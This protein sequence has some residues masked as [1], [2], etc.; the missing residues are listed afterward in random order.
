MAKQSVKELGKVLPDHIRLL[1]GLIARKPA[2]FTREWAA[3]IDEAFHLYTRTGIVDLWLA[4]NRELIEFGWPF[5]AYLDLRAETERVPREWSLLRNRRR[6]LLDAVFR[7][8]GVARITLYAG[9]EQAAG[10]DGQ[11]V[12][13]TLMVC[14]FRRNRQRLFHLLE[15]SPVL[16]EKGQ[17]VS[18]VQ[19]AF[20]RRFWAACITTIVPLLD[21]IMRSYFGTEKLNV[22]IQVLRDAFMREANLRPKD[23]MP[24]YA[25]WEGKRDPETGNA[26]APT[27]EEDLR[28]P[29]VL[30]S[31]FFEFADR[32]YQWYR[33]T[34]THP[35]TPLNRHA[36][37][38]CASEFW[39]Q[40]NAVRMLTFLD[41]TLRLEKPLKVLVHGEEAAHALFPDK[42]DE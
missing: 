29:G 20:E 26:F 35:Q 30:L 3:S 17:I 37:M 40:A 21:Y 8:P 4:L 10:K 25:V 18:D 12:C 11:A 2:E 1:S 22:T 41:L 38:H 19:G 31:S 9:L 16:A 36:I 5:P 24:G 34:E 42:A 6:A 13:D 28:L 39:S 33:S 23:L 27:L 15:S 7:P 32:Y 14:L